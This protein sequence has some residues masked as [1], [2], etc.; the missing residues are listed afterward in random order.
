MDRAK[1]GKR[2][3]DLRGSQKLID[4]ARALGVTPGC[5]ANYECGL[6][7]PPDDMKIKIAKY[8]KRSVNSIFYAP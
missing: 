8:Y 2:L 1:I 6:R 5:I 3:R 4:A 7:I